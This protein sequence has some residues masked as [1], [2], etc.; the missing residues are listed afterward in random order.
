MAIYIV[1]YEDGRKGR[2]GIEA[3]SKEDAESIFWDDFCYYSGKLE[4]H[5][6]NL[7]ITEETPVCESPETEEKPLWSPSDLKKREVE[8]LPLHYPWRED[9]DPSIF[10]LDNYF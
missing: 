3:D 2:F 4:N 5:K 8:E 10:D 9:I 1:E 6:F 7:D